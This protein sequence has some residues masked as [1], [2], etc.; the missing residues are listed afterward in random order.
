MREAIASDVRAGLVLVL[1]QK[2]CSESPDR[3]KGHPAS[4]NQVGQFGR[5]QGN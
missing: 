4:V 5:N 2:K 1:N 3:C